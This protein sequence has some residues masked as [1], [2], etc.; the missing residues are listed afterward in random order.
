MRW[1]VSLGLVRRFHYP[2]WGTLPMNLR[3][4]ENRYPSEEFRCWYNLG[5]DRFDGFPVVHSRKRVPDF[6]H[7]EFWE[8]YPIA[9]RWFEQLVPES[10]RKLLD[11]LALPPF[12]VISDADDRTLCVVADLDFVTHDTIRRIQTDFLKQYPLW[13]V[14]LCLADYCCV[15]VYPDAVRYGNAPLDVDPDLGLAE[16]KRRGAALWEEHLRPARAQVAFLEERL[17][18]VLQAMG[19]GSLAV[20]GVLDRYLRD[21]DQLAVFVLAPVSM[22]RSVIKSIP[23]FDEDKSSL[24]DIFRVD[25]QGRLISQYLESETALH[26]VQCFLLPAEYRGPLKFVLEDTGESCE[27]VVDDASIARAKLE[28]E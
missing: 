22:Y 27:F 12:Y 6:E 9:A 14:F 21:R 19:S 1:R 10:D 25:P 4:D 16:V 28:D 13:R 20:I 15:V 17:P 26:S 7:C 23:R 2:R 24:I 5:Y 11:P 8:F 3:S 18:A